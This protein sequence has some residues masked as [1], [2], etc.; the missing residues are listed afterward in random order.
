VFVLVFFDDI[1]IFS[2]SWTS[3]LQHVRAVLQCLR[4]HNLI[5]KRSKCI[6]GT[7]SM[8]YLGHVILAQGVAMDADKVSLSKHGLLPRCYA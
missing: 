8:A 5:V 7:T 4:E 6:F 2:D 1:L 3:H